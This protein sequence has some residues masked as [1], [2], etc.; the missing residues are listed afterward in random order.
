MI[1]GGDR[2]NP[3]RSG[4][5]ATMSVKCG[6]PQRRDG[7]PID[8]TQ[9]I[10]EVGRE[11]RFAGVSREE[12]KKWYA[13][14]HLARVL[15]DKAPNYLKQ[16][17]GWSYHAPS[18][19]HDA[20][21]LALGMTFRPGRDYLFP[22]YRDLTDLRRRR[23]HPRRDP[24]ERHVKG[25]RRRVW[26]PAHVEPLRQDP[27]SASRTSPPPSP[28]TPSTPPGSARAIKTYGRTPSSSAPSASPRTPRAISTRPST[29]PRGRSSRS[30][31]SSRTTATAS[32]CPRAT[33]RPISTRPTIS[34]GS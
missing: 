13:L 24:A 33:R 19:G 3:D 22:Y 15:D 30:S 17:L 1:A 26:R 8:E 25:D 5:V 11:Q 32:R 18:A 29:A 9:D 21:Q 6:F 4:R 10:V 7:G 34:R 23:S 31:S 2:G 20:I 12:V 14:M 16:G 28:T 27:R